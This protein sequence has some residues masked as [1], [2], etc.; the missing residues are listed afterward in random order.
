MLHRSF[1]QKNVF[2]LS[3]LLFFVTRKP[4][5]LFNNAATFDSKRGELTYDTTVQRNRAIKSE[6]ALAVSLIKIKLALTKLK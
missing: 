2:N 3:C 5:G 4:S 6:V 1:T